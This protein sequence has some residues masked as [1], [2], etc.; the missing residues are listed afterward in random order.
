[1]QVSLLIST[2]ILVRILVTSIIKKELKTLDWNQSNAAITPR[3]EAAASILKK[4]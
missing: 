4:V 2:V 3:Q 1:M